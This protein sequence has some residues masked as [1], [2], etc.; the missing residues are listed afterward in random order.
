MD[1]TTS[2]TSKCTFYSHES[3]EKSRYGNEKTDNCNKN[4]ETYEFAAI[5][6]KLLT[7]IRFLY[8]SIFLAEIRYHVR[9]KDKK[10]T[11][12]TQNRIYALVIFCILGLLRVI[13]FSIRS[14][15]LME[16]PYCVKC[17]IAF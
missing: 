13:L 14:F 7:I 8:I 11:R 5:T 16:V 1:S 10:T 15:F 4:G 9:T 6:K 3:L 12:R 2:K 17:F